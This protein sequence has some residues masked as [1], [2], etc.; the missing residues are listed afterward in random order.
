MANALVSSG[1][2][3]TK[4]GIQVQPARLRNKRSFMPAVIRCTSLLVCIALWYLASTNK[5]NLIVNFENVP[6]PAAVCQAAVQL[7]SSPKFQGHLLS[8]I[9]RVFS[10]F[11]CA[12]VLAIAIGLGVGRSKLLSVRWYATA[13]KPGAGFG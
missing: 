8:S 13:G 11:G 5:W 2:R 7:V 3:L 4:P 12:A 1:S 9:A 6:S 10:G